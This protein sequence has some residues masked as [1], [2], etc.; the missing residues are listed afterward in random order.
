MEAP[1]DSDRG[2]AQ[3]DGLV[4]AQRDPVGRV[5][6]H[7]EVRRVFSRI[8][9]EEAKLIRA[10]AGKTRGLKGSI[11]LARARAPPWRYGLR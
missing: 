10:R 6:H 3:V 5:G 8:L 1:K 4:L 2:S 7:D 9:K 11:V